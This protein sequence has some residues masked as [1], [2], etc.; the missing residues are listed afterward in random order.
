MG[1]TLRAEFRPAFH[2]FR[3][4]PAPPRGLGGKTTAAGGR[5]S[6]RSFEYSDSASDSGRGS[7]RTNG[8]R[9]NELLNYPESEAL[10][11]AGCETEARDHSHW[12]SFIIGV[13]SLSGWDAEELPAG[14]QAEVAPLIAK[15]AFGH[16]RLSTSQSSLRMTIGNW[17]GE[18]PKRKRCRSRMSLTG[19]SE[20]ISTERSLRF[21]FD[22]RVGLIG[23][24]SARQGIARLQRR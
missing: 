22:F 14:V 21:R 13:Y 9:M 15:S 16:F 18:R 1:A 10:N 2:V 24:S 5:R 6:F 23:P 7:G 17:R 4:S 19:F 12:R 8:P 20:T 3:A 11:G